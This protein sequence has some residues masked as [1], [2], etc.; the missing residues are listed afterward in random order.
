MVEALPGVFRLFSDEPQLAVRA[1]G[2]ARYIITGEVP[3]FRDPALRFESRAG[4]AEIALA[5]RS[6][7]L[8]ALRALKRRLPRGVR[9]ESKV[10]ADGGLEVMLLET[11]Q[12][13]ARP[14]YVQVITTDLRQ[15]IR[16]LDDNRF[17]LIGATQLRCLI[18][19]RVDTRRTL[20]WIPAR[21]TAH[22]TAELIADHVPAGYTAE[23]EGA[24][25]TLWKDAD[26]RTIA[27]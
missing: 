26:L 6:G 9:A 27:A 8:D 15:R 20:T 14:P 17:E 19:L 11:T 12:P 13:A 22:A 25:L 18:T 4:N 3:V 23:V 21:T 10:A 16:R 2:F 7:P 24:V 1:H 5:D